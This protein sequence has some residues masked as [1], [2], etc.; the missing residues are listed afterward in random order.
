MTYQEPDRSAESN[1]PTTMTQVL[2]TGSAPI[3]A[4]IEKTPKDFQEKL[5]RKLEEILKKSLEQMISTFSDEQ[6][7]ARLASARAVSSTGTLGL[8]DER[9]EIIDEHVKEMRKEVRQRT[10]IGSAVTGSFGLLGQFADLPA[11]YL[12]AMRSVGEVAISYGFDP[13]QEREQAFILH[14]LRIGHQPGRR[15]RLVALDELTQSSLTESNNLVS[16]ASYALSGRG[17]SVA[18]KQI[19]ALLAKRKLGAMVPLIGA[20]VNAGVNWHLMGNL[21]DTANRGYRSKAL[22]YRNRVTA[23]RASND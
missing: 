9:M 23:D 5:S 4:L 13:R 18:S 3:E 21:L 17:I 7:D 20:L 16:E 8:S 11:F 19:A 22:L 1:Q 12:Y 15:K 6:V 10:M 14:L 2:Q